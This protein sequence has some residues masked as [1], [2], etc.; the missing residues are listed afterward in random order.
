MNIEKAKKLE[1]LWEDREFKA[2][3]KILANENICYIVDD[4]FEGN[5]YII[6]TKFGE[7]YINAVYNRGD[8]EHVTLIPS[9]R[10]MLEKL[11]K[12][13]KKGEYNHGFEIETGISGDWRIQYRTERFIKH[14][15]IDEALADMLI[16][17]I[18]NKYIEAK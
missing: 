7:G 1:P 4:K 17:L 10:D 18:D 9:T 6:S 11:P 12:T 5:K 2:G 3:D 14:K 16:Y 8:M 13:I 15:N